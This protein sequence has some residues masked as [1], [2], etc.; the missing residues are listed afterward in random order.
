L[1]DKFAIN[2]NEVNKELLKGFVTV[3][4]KNNENNSENLNIKCQSI[5]RF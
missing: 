3:G 5:A 1:N 2:W 4:K